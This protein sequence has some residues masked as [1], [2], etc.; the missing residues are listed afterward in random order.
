MRSGSEGIAFTRTPFMIGALLGAQQVM[1]KETVERLLTEERREDLK[2]APLKL[3]AAIQNLVAQLTG[4]AEV[5][6]PLPS[7]EDED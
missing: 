3:E 7:I 6:M 4:Q 5:L 1:D 2:G